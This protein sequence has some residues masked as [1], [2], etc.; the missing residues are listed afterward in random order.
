MIQISNNQVEPTKVSDLRKTYTSL[1]LLQSNIGPKKQNS[2]HPQPPSKFIES[3]SKKDD[4]NVL[5]QNSYN[6]ARGAPKIK[7]ESEDFDLNQNNKDV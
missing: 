3:D 5:Y 7:K 4:F 1:N 2:S 6:T